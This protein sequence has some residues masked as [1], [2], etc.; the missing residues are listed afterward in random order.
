MSE[1]GD[2]TIFIS[3]NGDKL[4]KRHVQ[5][6]ISRIQEES[7]LEEIRVSPHVLRHTAAT[8]AVENGLDT[9]SLKR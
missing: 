6:T 9:F 8:L 2:D 3:Q 7:G 1:I 5:R 4:K